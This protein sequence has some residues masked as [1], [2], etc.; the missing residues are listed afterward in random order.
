ML[1]S[2]LL[3]AQDLDYDIE[4]NIKQF[5]EADTKLFSEGDDQFRFFIMGEYHFKE[6]N[7]QLYFDTFKNLY[8]NNNVRLVFMESGYANGIILNHY[9]KTGDNESLSLVLDNYQF[10]KWIY[11]KLKEFYDSLP[12]DEKFEFVGVDLEIY[13]A[14]RKFQYVTELL[15]NDKEIPDSLNKIISDFI[16]DAHK[17][18]TDIAQKSFDK[19]YFDWKKNKEKYKEL[20]GENYQTYITLLQRM[21]RS[22][23][24]ELY[25]YNYGKDSIK[26]TK[27]ERFM[28]NNIV[29]EVE[30]HPECN[31][32]GQFGLAHIGLN[33]FLIVSENNSFQSFSTKL[34]TNKKSPLRNKVCSIAILYF[35]KENEFPNKL[36]YYYRNFQYY[37]S[38]KK[39]LPNKIYKTLKE[40]T[41]I[42]KTYIVSLSNSRNPAIKAAYKNFQFIIFK[43]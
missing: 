27:R 7:S 26:Q 24:F 6:E 28:Y 11:V 42:D 2:S 16:D 14:D 4:S 25:N 18:N 15:T 10:K 33:R 32:F 29:R 22:Y 21:K 5:N 3:F 17:K 31:Y 43:R 23:R 35:D 34:N 40:N 9:L 12:D 8:K 39:Y 36:I 1:T 38:R 41:E 20:M 30:Q 19:I 13:E 37:L